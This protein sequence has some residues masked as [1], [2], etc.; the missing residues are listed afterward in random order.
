[1]PRELERLANRTALLSS[2][3]H[4][5]K[6][7]GDVNVSLGLSVSESVPAAVTT[8]LEGGMPV[9]RESHCST[10]DDIMQA[11]SEQLGSGFP[12]LSSSTSRA[13]D[14]SWNDLCGLD[15]AKQKILSVMHNP[16]VFRKLLSLQVGLQ[17][18]FY[19]SSW[20]SV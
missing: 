18:S 19:S 17:I 4:F 6:M 12:L 3:R 5:E 9:P 11:L 10:L 13:A 16:V 8:A 14:L 1:M 7:K 15:N 20:H 2:R